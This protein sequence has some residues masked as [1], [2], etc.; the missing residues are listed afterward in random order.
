MPGQHTARLPAGAE[1]I[2]KRSGIR[3]RYHYCCRYYRYFLL[4][5]ILIHYYYSV[6][7]QHHKNCSRSVS[8]TGNAGGIAIPTCAAFSRISRCC[9]HH[10][11][12]CPLGL[13]PPPP[14]TLSNSAQ[15]LQCRTSLGSAVFLSYGTQGMGCTHSGSCYSVGLTNM[16]TR[17]GEAQSHGGAESQAS[18]LRFPGKRRGCLAPAFSSGGLCLKQS[19]CSLETPHPGVTQGLTA[20]PRS[21]VWG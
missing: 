14:R 16:G 8:G 2:S 1:P 9:A 15:N 6:N 19:C 11:L 21:S 7:K 13:P 3:P 4:L 18:R 5:F 12:T 20:A 17:R 10:L